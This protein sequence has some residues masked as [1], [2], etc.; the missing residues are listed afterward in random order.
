MIARVIDSTSVLRPKTDLYLEHHGVKGQKWGVINVKNKVAKSKKGIKMDLQLFAHKSSSRKTVKL[1][2]SEYAHIMSELRTNI[3]KEEK[4]H[5]I[6][7][8]AIGNYTYSFENH[9][10]DTYRI[11]GKRKI[12]QSTTGILKR[13]TDED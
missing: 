5:T 2:T 10:D 4:T 13:I 3:T 12:P 8:K 11:I 7:N 1:K 9:F 6:I